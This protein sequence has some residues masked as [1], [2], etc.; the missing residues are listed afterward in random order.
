MVLGFGDYLAV[1]ASQTFRRTWVPSMKFR[2]Q[3]VYFDW[4]LLPTHCL[5]IQGPPLPRFGGLGFASYPYLG[6]AVGCPFVSSCV[7]LCVRVCV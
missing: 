4:R 5:L 6:A 1:L 2:S 3:V 7:S